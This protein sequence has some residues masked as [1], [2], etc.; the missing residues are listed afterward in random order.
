MIPASSCTGVT[1]RLEAV[2]HAESLFAGEA[3]ADG[4]DGVECEEW[5]RC[6]S[7]RCRCEDECGSVFCPFLL[8]P[9]DGNIVTLYTSL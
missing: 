6:L 7:G 1:E 5:K 2:E 8:F 9:L 4:E 3:C